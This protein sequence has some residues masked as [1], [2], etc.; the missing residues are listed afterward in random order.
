MSSLKH[1]DAAEQAQILSNLSAAIKDAGG[2][3]RQ[4]RQA[5]AFLEAILAENPEAFATGSRSVGAQLK[6][7]L[8]EMRRVSSESDLIASEVNLGVQRGRL[9]NVRKK[10]PSSNV[11][12][13]NAGSADD[14]KRAARHNRIRKALTN[15]AV[16][17]LCNVEQQIDI[18]ERVQRE[19]E[20]WI[21]N[22]DLPSRVEDS[23]YTP[24]WRPEFKVK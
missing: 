9:D 17:N 19:K 16:V 12:D 7:C 5:K 23:M 20:L 14:R 3:R 1:I 15:M 10:E 21:L 13:E 11:V 2:S 8:K 24:D 4:A 18:N 22:S 6:P